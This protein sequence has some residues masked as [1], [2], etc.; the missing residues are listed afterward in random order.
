MR[1]GHGSAGGWDEFGPRRQVTRSVGNVLFELD[2]QP[3][4]DLYERY[5][6]PMIQGTARLRLAISDPGLRSAQQPDSAVVRTVLADRSRGAFDDVRRRRAARLDG[7]TDARKSRSPGGRRR[8]GGAAGPPTA[9]AA[10]T[11]SPATQLSILVS[12]IGR[13]L[14][15]GQRTLEEVEAVGAELG[16]DSVSRLGFYSYGE[17]SPHAASGHC[18]LHNQTMTVTD[19]RR[20]PDPEKDAVVHK[21]LAQTARQGDRQGL[22]RGRSADAVELVSAAYEESTAIAAAPTVDLVDDRGARPAQ[23]QASNRPSRSAPAT[24]RG[25]AELRAQ[26]MR[27]DA[28]LSQHVARLVMFDAAGAAGHL[29]STLHRDVRLVARRRKARAARCANCSIAG[30]KAEHSPAILTSTSRRLRRAIAEASVQQSSSELA[31]GR[32]IADHRSAHGGR[33]VGGDARG[34][35]RAAA[36]R[37]R[38]IAHMAR[39]DALTDLP[40]RMLFRERLAR[41]LAA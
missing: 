19:H 15:M 8:G 33:R 18:E 7:A 21:L 3:A 9:H 1:I 2:G 14:L 23:A 10:A 35:H 41:A 13:R 39:H 30:S 27:F 6:G 28:A 40:N 4:L 25:K 16:A 31:D 12:C 11:R 37:S 36:G 29:Q 24:A 17:I 5:L 34:H 32:T 22:R 38:Q 20:R 26:N